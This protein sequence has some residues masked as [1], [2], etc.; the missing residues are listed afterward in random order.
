VFPAYAWVRLRI[1]HQEPVERALVRGTDQEHFRKGGSPMRAIIYVR[2]STDEQAANGKTLEMQEERCRA[3]VVSKGWECAGVYSDP[4]YSAKSLDVPA[5][6][7][8]LT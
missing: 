1:V 2:C 7:R 8:R 3:F 5:L 6:P 4:G